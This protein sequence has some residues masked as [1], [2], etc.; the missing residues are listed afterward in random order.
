M[1][2]AMHSTL[3]LISGGDAMGVVGDIASLFLLFGACLLF[4]LLITRRRVAGRKS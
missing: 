3:F 2:Y 1:K 4:L